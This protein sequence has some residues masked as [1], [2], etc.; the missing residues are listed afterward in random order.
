MGELDAGHGALGLHESGDVGQSRNL[1]VTPEADVAVGDAAL[2]RDGGRLDDDKAEAAQRELAL[3]DGV[4]GGH[5]PVLGLVHA[6]RR[7]RQAVAE[8]DVAQGD[9]LEKLSHQARVS[10]A[11]DRR[12]RR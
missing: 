9:G 11:P 8:G 12:S 5:E 2:R 10:V 3:V 6:H 4:V 7:D 1:L